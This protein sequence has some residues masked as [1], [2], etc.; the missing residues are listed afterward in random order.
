MLL[1][2]TSNGRH[3]T[4]LASHFLYSCSRAASSSHLLDVPMARDNYDIHTVRLS[5]VNI[6]LH[7]EWS[8]G[9]DKKTEVDVSRLVVVRSAYNR[10]VLDGVSQSQRLH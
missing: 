4:M 2:H 5:M 6:I 9:V 1:G 10:T 7:L 3:V 8:R